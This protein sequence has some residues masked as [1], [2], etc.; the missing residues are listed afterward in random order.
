[1]GIE[2]ATYILE[3]LT[4]NEMKDLNSPEFSGTLMMA[5]Y[6]LFF[7]RAPECKQL[8]GNIFQE[9]IMNSTDS[10]LKQRAIFLYRLL[11]T[12]ITLAKE[13]AEQQTDS[14]FEEFF[15]D[16]NDEVRERLF[17]EFNSLSIV[18]QKPSERFLKETELKQSIASEKKY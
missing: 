1:M 6:K 5:I 15:E 18:Y 17:M 3:S 2:E 14:E 11:R 8:L 7:K 4:K 10:T 16:K 9:I 13:V 12:N